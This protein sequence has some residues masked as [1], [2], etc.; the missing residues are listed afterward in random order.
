MQLQEM[1][2]VFYFHKLKN[3]KGSGELK[4]LGWILRVFCC[5]REGR[6]CQMY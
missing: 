4:N 5:S 2:E 1:D 6:R 3:K